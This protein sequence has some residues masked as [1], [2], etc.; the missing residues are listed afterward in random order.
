MPAGARIVRHPEGAGVLIPA[1][2]ALLVAASLG[3]LLAVR[4]IDA[5]VDPVLAPLRRL[6][7]L[8]DTVTCTE[9]APAEPETLETTTATEAAERLGIDRAA[10][11]KRCR[12]GQI[13][14]AVQIEGRW[15]I[16]SAALP[17]G[18]AN[19]DGNHDR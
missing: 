16:P 3:R 10:V 18:E 5:P 7:L 1:E 4:P 19:H 14:G 13:P 2:D 8:A 6:L 12:S 9:P 11:A 17:E 15:R